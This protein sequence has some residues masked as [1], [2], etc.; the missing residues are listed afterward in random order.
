[1]RPVSDAKR[2]ADPVPLTATISDTVGK[3]WGSMPTARARYY[4]TALERQ[5]RGST[6]PPMDGSWRSVGGVRCSSS[7]RA[8]LLW[9]AMLACP[10]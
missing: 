6:M 7:A 10:S 3:R 2:T 4:Q 9:A 5:L 8:P 1:M